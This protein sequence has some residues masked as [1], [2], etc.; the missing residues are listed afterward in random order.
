MSSEKIA[1]LSSFIDDNVGED[2]KLSDMSTAEA[3]IMFFPG[4]QTN[5]TRQDLLNALSDL[6]DPNVGTRGGKT[7][8]SVLDTFDT[9]LAKNRHRLTN[10][11]AHPMGPL[12]QNSN[13]IM[14]LLNTLFNEIS[15]KPTVVKKKS[16]LTSYDGK[17]PIIYRGVRQVN[18]TDENGNRTVATPAELHK[19]FREEDGLWW[20][21]GVYGQGIYNAQSL[22]TAQGYSNDRTNGV[23]VSKM[24]ADANV[25]ATDSA[26]DPTYRNLQSYANQMLTAYLISIGFVPGTA[27]FDAKY[28][29]YNS[30]LFGDDGGRAGFFGYDVLHI[31]SVNYWV[32]LNRGAIVIYDGTHGDW[33]NDNS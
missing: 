21:H 25:L 13:K 29:E 18:Y 23:S 12:S 27:A 8:K 2:G 22:N 28:N 16:E 7:F 26:E 31:T 32:I 24:S 14:E 20:G 11:D 3:T 17:S 30:E 15:D 19:K 6:D 5:S 33:V 9:A 1:E 10:Q 4:L